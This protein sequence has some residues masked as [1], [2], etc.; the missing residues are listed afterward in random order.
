[1]LVSQTSHLKN[2]LNKIYCLTQY[3]LITQE[4]WDL[5]MPHWLEAVVQ[6]VTEKELPELKMAIGYEPSFFF[7][8]TVYYLLYYIC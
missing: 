6:D 3:N 4:V 8:F 5:I 1:M 7:Y 2:G